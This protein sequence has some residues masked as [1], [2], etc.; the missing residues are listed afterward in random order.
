MKRLIV[1]SLMILMFMKIDAQVGPFVYPTTKKVKQTDKYFKV[2]V[3]D[4]YRWLEDD[5]SEETMSWVDQQNEVTF[6]YLNSLPYRDEL[7]ERLT[8]LWDYPKMGVPF[9]KGDFLFYYQNSGTQNQSV[10]F[11][12][13]IYTQYEYVLLDPNKMSEAGTLSIGSISVSPDGKY[14]GYTVSEGGSDWS[15]IKLITVP[16]AEPLKDEINW[17]KFSGISWHNDGFYYSSYDEP[18]GSA[19]SQK[20][21][22]HKIYYHIIGTPQS[23][24]ALIY[25]NKNFPLRNYGVRVTDDEE[26]LFLS[27]TESTSGNALYF[28]STKNMN[29]EFVKIADG[30]SYDYNIVDVIEGRFLMLTNDDA[31]SYRLVW[32]DPAKPTKK[33]WVDYLSAKENV[34]QSVS[35]VGPYIYVQYMEKAFS[36]GFLYDYNGKEVIEIKLP[37]MGTLGGLSGDRK[38]DEAYFAFTSFTYPSTIYKFNLRDYSTEIFFESKVDVRPDYYITEQV[39]YPSKDGEKVSMFIVRHKDVK[40][41]GNN[42]LL[43]YGYGGFNISL[44]PSFSLSR[45]LFLEQGGILAIPNLRGGGE[46]GSEW[47]RAGTK[48]QKQNTFNDFIAA[49]EYLIKEKYTNSKKIAIQ[50]GSNG[51]LLVGA[52]MLQR[53]DLFKVALPAVG[54]LDMLRYH[55]FTIGWAWATDY[56]TSDTKEEFEYLYKYSP[57]HNIKSGVNYP[58]T[59]VTTADHDDRVVPAHSFKFIS[60]LQEHYKGENPMLIRIDKQAG[61][62]AGKPTSKVI[63][64]A[65]D[66]WAFVFYHLGMKYQQMEYQD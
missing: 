4:P 37:T 43:L 25:E 24:D 23:K 22:F 8:Q 56:G 36:R 66:I 48:L 45:L 33:D 57:L 9:Q 5:R 53:P 6:S 26:Y 13:N 41:D 1:F 39:F 52:T 11:C 49:A 18:K 17:V 12:K 60:T 55:K 31:P 28:K 38:F 62:G 21:E 51:G 3:K 63:D 47:H 27:E 16:F 54:V 46:Y 61:H 35:L 7:R 20:N 59:L 2:K 15:T 10:L 44:T 40:L 58:A 42:P 30:F 14:L 34:L 32:V 29:S 65:I 50:G 19:L 64:E